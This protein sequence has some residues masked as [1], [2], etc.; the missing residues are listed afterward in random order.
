MIGVQHV[1]TKNSTL[2]SRSEQ[3]IGETNH[4]ELRRLICGK[5]FEL[6]AYCWSSW[7]MFEFSGLSDTTRLSV[8][9]NAKRRWKI[10]QWG[11]NDFF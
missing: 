5:Q 8:K 11:M 10:W 3:S 9:V 6:Y 1:I 4:L 2:Y 7:L